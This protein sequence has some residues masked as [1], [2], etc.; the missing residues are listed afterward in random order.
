MLKHAKHTKGNAGA[1]AI[2]EYN[3]IDNNRIDNNN[4]NNNRI[5]NNIKDEERNKDDTEKKID[6]AKR[7]RE[8]FQ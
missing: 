7:A 5:D 1:D 4:N 3:I 6:Y 2:I 8:L